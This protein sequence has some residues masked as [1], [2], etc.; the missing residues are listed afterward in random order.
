MP[1]L[2]VEY[3]CGNCVIGQKYFSTR[4]GSKGKITYNHTE[5]GKTTTAQK[6][7]NDKKSE[8]HFDVLTNSNFGKGDYFITYTFKRGQLPKLKNGKPDIKRIKRIWKT[9][10]DKLRA[11]YRKHGLELKYIYAF[12]FEDVR[13]HFHILI[14]NDGMNPA[15]LPEWPYGSPEWKTLDGR[16][17]HT[18]GEYF[19][20]GTPIEII[21]ENGQQVTL[22]KR[23]IVQSSR[24]LYKP[25]R[26]VRRLK[27]SNWS[28]K[29][30]V[31]KGYYLQVLE[32]GHIENPFNQGSYRY[33][34]YCM[35]RLN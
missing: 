22:H 29:P 13:P 2:K 35:V 6:R 16:K 19:A 33:Q 15:D 7:C 21:E 12:Q 31:K 20:R 9:Y 3:N 8:L 18:I 30:K 5:N 24:N 26:R 28:E 27:R 23:G 1:W 32:N 17:R 10:R 14:N 11:C 34:Y 4:Y 25:K